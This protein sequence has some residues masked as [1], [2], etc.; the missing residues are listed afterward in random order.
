MVL[1]S[2]TGEVVAQQLEKVSGQQQRPP[3]QIV[4]DY[5]SDIKKGIGLYKRRQHPKLIWSHDVTHARALLLQKELKEDE[6][7]QAFMSHCNV[8]RQQIKQTDLYFLIPP[9]KRTKARYLNIES[10]IR[11]AQQLLLYQQQAD[12]SA[13]NPTHQL[14]KTALSLLQSQL[15]PQTL[16]DLTKLEPKTYPDRQ[17]FCQHLSLYLGADRWAEYQPA[18][19]GLIALNL[20]GELQM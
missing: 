7:Y 19:E 17:S 6:T 15:D 10:H 20:S 14:D 4:S 1:S 3:L 8:T 11:W 16:T 5:G 18:D 13:I 9:L 2:C 12:F